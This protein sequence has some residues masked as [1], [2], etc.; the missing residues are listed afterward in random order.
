MKN[1]LG[2]NIPKLGF[3]LMRLPMNGKEIDM[4]QTKKMV[5]TFMEKG[6]TYFDTAYVY[7]NGKSEV[8][9]KEAIVDRYP[10][11][12]FQL[13]SKLPL[14]DLKDRADMERVFQESLTRAGTEYFDF[15]LLHAMDKSRFE[16]AEQ[17]GAWDFVKEKKA[18]GKIKHIGFSFHDSAEVLEEALRKY[19][20]DTEFVQ[21]QINY[22]DWESENVQSRKCYEVALKYNKPIIIMEPIKGGSLVNLP[23]AAQEVFK[24]TRPELSIP[25]WAIRYCASLEGIITVLS[26][27][28][29]EE[30]LNDNVSYMEH[31]EPLNEEERK[32]IVQA[33]DAINAVPTI[34]CTKCKYCV[35]DCPQ[36]I[37]IP[38]IFAV[39]NE[40][41]KFGVEGQKPMNVWGY[42]EATKEGGKASDCIQCGSCQNH[43]PQHIEIIEELQK[44]AALYEG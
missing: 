9:M 4:E 42:G 23:K 31:F 38:E 43:C 32:A 28:S 27:M 7:I 15:Y 22:I 29:T 18:E 30:Q 20:E 41:K 39:A 33:V 11:E 34:P 13:A 3:G 10:R 36:K 12:S 17:L 8:A 5:D 2:E 44:I 21:L 25:S 40:N 24:K 14:W 6:F 16:K 35:D 26:G 19:G 37:N 1:Y